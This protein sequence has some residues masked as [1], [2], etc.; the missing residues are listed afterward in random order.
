MAYMTLIKTIKPETLGKRFERNADGKITKSV[1]ANVWKGK[2]KALD[3]VTA[4]EL[5]S[6][7]AQ[8]CEDHNDALMS[9][10]FIGAGPGEVVNLLSKKI[11]AE[12]L[13]CNEDDAPSGVQV[14][15]GQKYVA[16]LKEGIEPATWVLIDADNPEGIPVEWAALGMQQR[17]KMLEPIIPGISTCTRVEYRSSSAR[18]VKN[19]ETPGGATHAWMQISDATKL[20]MLRAH[21]RVQM[22]LKGLSFPSPRYSTDTGEMIGSE[23]R[24]VIDLAVWVLGRLVFCSKPEVLAEG[25][26]VANAGVTIVN[27]GGGLLDVSDIEVPTE[28]ALRALREKT[29]QRLSFS[30]NGLGLTVKDHS[31]LSWDTL[32]EVKGNTRSLRDVVKHMKQGEKLRCE[33]PFRASQSE[34]AFIRVRE[35][36]FPMLHDV[37]TST[38]YFLSEEVDMATIGRS[39]GPQWVQEFNALYAWV[40]GPKSIYRFEFGDFIKQNE[41]VTQYRNDPL[42]V[43]DEDGK[44]KRHCRV[45]SWISDK[46]R[47][48]YRDLVFAPAELAIT[49][50]NE[51]NTWTGFSVGPIAG[52]VEPYKALLNYLFPDPVERRYV[53]QWLAHK[54]KH[55][56]VKMNTALVVW[57]AKQGVGKNILFETVGAIIGPKHACVIEQKELGG[58]FNSWA[59]NR[60][61]VIGDEVLS[62]GDR[63]DADRFKGL[64]TGTMLRINEKNQPEYDIANH[65]SFVF[66]SNHD[67]AVHLEDGNRRYFVAEIK[68]KPLA[69]KFYADYAAWRDNGGLAALHYYLINDVDL[70]GFDPKAP[71]PAT[72]AKRT[73]VAAGRSG[74]EQWMADVLE[75]PV[76]SFGGAVATAKI[77]KSAYELATNDNRAT[78]KAVSNAAK[79][80]GA[81]FRTS[82]IRIAGNQKVRVMSLTDHE[83]WSGRSEVE[84]AEELV[85]TQ[86]SAIGM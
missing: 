69:P 78:L 81:Q 75:D 42:I 51:I 16:R 41:L 23:A 12:T 29:G 4:E 6:I 74:L 8:V 58:N 82:Q 40:E 47:A 24:T 73:M 70:T 45:S 18:V 20:D 79:K 77:L 54:L 28:I 63:R 57:S 50:K 31:S 61:F 26:Y 67:D 66:L 56:G 10:S 25:Y 83:A 1:V 84:W 53:E 9:G 7:V 59:K 85:R 21:V 46:N 17:L 2:A 3:L 76:G 80:A 27:E 19:G 60:L 33:T 5:S 38:T 15:G 11:L 48:Q 52:N 64:I 37:G 14:V 22:Q 49:S 39:V 86:K 62:S 43:K 13:G 55:P 36:G 32:I 68:G 30:I 72:E 65:T 44:E 34:A 71:P 35:N